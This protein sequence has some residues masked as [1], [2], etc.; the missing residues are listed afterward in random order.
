MK[1]AL[2]GNR[3]GPVT[4]TIA[5]LQ[6][7]LDPVVS[8]ISSWRRELGT[9]ESVE[10]VDCDV[11]EA[12]VAM[13]PLSWPESKELLLETESEWIAYLVNAARTPNI[14]GQVAYI[15]ESMRIR[16]VLAS[17]VPSTFVR[18]NF[19]LHGSVQMQLFA[20]E[21]TEFLNIERSVG[22]FCEDGRWKFDASGTI[23]SFEQP[24][25]YRKSRIRDR[26]PPSLL[27]DYC[28][29]LGIRL[30]ETSFYRARGTLIHWKPTSSEKWTYA[31]VQRNLG[32]IET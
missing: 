7:G 1:T 28:D 2:L 29:H 30:F 25:E 27:A 12:L 6:A 8:F 15:T 26:F 23:Q 18:G 11:E 9:L 19:A 17:V 32:I 21:P 10:R 16:G 3:F 24:D 20:R 4:F 5:F 31:E 14:A 13:E 22:V